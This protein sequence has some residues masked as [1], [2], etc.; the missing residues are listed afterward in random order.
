MCMG[1]GGGVGRGRCFQK[2]QLCYKGDVCGS[3]GGPGQD[4]RWAE[5]QSGADLKWR[6][7]GPHEEIIPCCFLTVCSV[8]SLKPTYLSALLLTWKI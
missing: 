7:M 8:F 2:A 5:G 1:G 4:E 6:S 3:K